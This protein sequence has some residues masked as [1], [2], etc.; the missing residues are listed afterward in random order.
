M[1]D[2]NSQPQQIRKQNQATSTP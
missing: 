1:I 2:I